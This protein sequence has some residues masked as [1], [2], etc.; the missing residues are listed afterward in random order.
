MDNAQS[1]ADILDI[2][3]FLAKYDQIGF[4]SWDED[5]EFAV[6]CHDL[7]WWGCVEVEPLTVAT[8]P[9]LKQ[10]IDDVKAL[11]DLGGT[12]GHTLYCCRQRQMRPQKPCYDHL[13]EALHPLFDACGGEQGD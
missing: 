10:A 6:V 7:F 3:R 9:N 12:H 13:P 8:L 2:L 5:L 1:P 11:G 4:V